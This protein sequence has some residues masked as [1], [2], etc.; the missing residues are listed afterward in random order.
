VLGVECECGLVQ[1][2][3]FGVDGCFDGVH[4]LVYECCGELFGDGVDVDCFGL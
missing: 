2:E 4:W 1:F 3:L